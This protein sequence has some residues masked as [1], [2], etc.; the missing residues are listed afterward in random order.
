MAE[1]PKIVAETRVEFGKGAA[2]R[3][4]RADKIPAVLYG[5]GADPLHLTLPGHATMLAAK[6]ANAILEV[7][8][9]GRTGLVLVKDIQ[10][11]V[12]KPIIKHVDL[13]TVRRGDKFT[14]DVS[15]TVVGAAAPDTLVTV[16][17]NTVSLE[18]DATRIPDGVDVDVDGLPAGTQVLAKDLVLPPGVTLAIDEDTLVVNVSAAISA[19]VLE[20]DLAE[21]ETEAGVER[22]EPESDRDTEGESVE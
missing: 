2:R 8:V 16:E 13:V 5:H 4:R 19:E 7:T 21:A 6:V 22:A 17:T 11:D 3:I 1:Y 14:V 15:I 12:L 10:R 9:E 18:A 20:A